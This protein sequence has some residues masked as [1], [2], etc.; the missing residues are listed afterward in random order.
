[1]DPGG[2]EAGNMS[3]IADQE[4]SDFFGDLAEDLEVNDARIRGGS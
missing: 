3:D 2:H 1:M 4:G